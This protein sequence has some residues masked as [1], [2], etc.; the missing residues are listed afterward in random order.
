M[1]R[2]LIAG[3]TGFIGQ[4]LA[5]LLHQMG[6]DVSVIGTNP[7]PCPNLESLGIAI[8]F[9]DLAQSSLSQISSKTAFDYVVNL[10]GY[11]DHRP[12]S[13]SGWDVFEAHTKS[14][15]N[16]INA[17]D[18]D[19]LRTF[20]QVGTSDEYGNT[21]APQ[22][23]SH[24]E[25]CVAPYSLAKLTNTHLVQML[26]RN[27]SFPGVVVRPFLVYGPGQSDNRLIPFII[28]Q[29][30]DNKTFD[31]T[32]GEQFRDFIYIDD[33]CKGVISLFD[34]SDH[35]GSVFNVASGKGITVRHVIET[36]ISEAG[37][38]AANFGG[39]P[40][41]PGESMALFAD[42]SAIKKATG[43]HPETSL[44]D[45]LRFTIDAMKNGN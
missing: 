10:S 41:R 2:T 5:L 40:Y 6:H 42:I 43:W 39:K 13:D 24:R 21:K 30:L 3:G 7:R 16:I 20:V 18:K 9:G 19:T 37:G 28:Q 35:Y 45:G 34:Q 4:R 27:Q 26:A 38:G 33:F 29:C 11:I 17:L 1:P 14:T 31:T 15:V 23:E 25:S 32:P 22:H 36:V 44:K 12:I 8:H